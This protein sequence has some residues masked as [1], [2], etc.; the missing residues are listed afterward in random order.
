MQLGVTVEIVGHEFEAVDQ[1]IRDQLRRLPKECREGRALANLRATI[2]ELIGRSRFLGPLRVSGSRVKEDILGET[3]AQ[4]IELFFAEEFKGRSI[5]FQALESFRQLTIHDYPS[6]IIPVFLNMVSNSVY[7]VTRTDRPRQIRLTGVDGVAVISDTGPGIDPDD[8]SSL[9]RLFFSRRVGGR[10]VGLYLCRQNLA[11]G[12]HS[13][14]LVRSGPYSVLPGA[15][16]AIHFQ[17][18]S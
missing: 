12:G 14:E 4:N 1:R 10:G 13:I 6:R 7:W 17:G 9:F 11:A 3:I 5:R 8:E 16:F 2:D 15:N 18:V